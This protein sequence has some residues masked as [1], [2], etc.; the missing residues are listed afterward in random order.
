[1]KRTLLSILVIAGTGVALYAAQAAYVDVAGACN[2]VSFTAASGSLGMDQVAKDD[3]GAFIYNS[4]VVYGNPRIGSLL[5]YGYNN[6]N[7]NPY[8]YGQAFPEPIIPNNTYSYTVTSEVPGS[9][10]TCILS[11]CFGTP[12]V[13][14][15]QYQAKSVCQA[16]V[17]VTSNAVSTAPVPSVNT[18]NDTNL[19]S[20]TSP[21]QTNTSISLGIDVSKLNLG[22]YQTFNDVKEG[23]LTV[24][25]QDWWGWTTGWQSQIWDSSFSCSLTS[26]DTSASQLLSLA[27]AGDPNLGSSGAFWQYSYNTLS[28]DVYKLS[29]SNQVAIPTDATYDLLRNGQ[30][31]ATNLPATQTSYTDSGLEQGVSYAYT[32]R[33]PSIYARNNAT[34]IPTAVTGAYQPGFYLFPQGSAP[35]F[36]TA[37]IPLAPS[38]FKSAIFGTNGVYVPKASIGLQISIPDNAVGEY[39]TPGVFSQQASGG[40]ACV[41]V[42]HN[43]SSCI[44]NWNTPTVAT[45]SYDKTYDILRQVGSSTPQEIASKISITQQSYY[46]TN[47]TPGTTYTYTIRMPSIHSRDGISGGT[48]IPLGSSTPQ[49]LPA[50]ASPTDTTLTVTTVGVQPKPQ[51]QPQPQ[52][53]PQ[54]G[55]GLGPGSGSGSGGASGSTSTQPGFT[56][57][58]VQEVLP[59]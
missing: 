29:S 46:D 11:Y 8:Y 19:V 23:V 26:C 54:T 4:A 10:R 3:P 44:W 18:S 56:P 33:A 37:P 36:A 13:V 32:V 27:P 42:N 5:D 39:R 40:V 1:M 16:N 31:I 25:Y 15:E 57:G 22:H 49:P 59:Q 24:T 28:F 41:A 6:P 55:T 51:P 14:T 58:G 43:S 7:Y 50:L 12:D 20:V 34:N 17:S 48:F 53:P 38:Q 47:L 2:Y 21:K 52:Q 9:S 35:S 30:E 45:V